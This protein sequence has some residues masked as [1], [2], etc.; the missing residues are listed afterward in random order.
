MQYREINTFSENPTK[1]RTF[2]EKDVEYFNV[3][4]DGEYTQ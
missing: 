1:H 3:E 2:C 4:A